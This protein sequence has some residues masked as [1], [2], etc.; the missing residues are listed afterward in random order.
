MNIGFTI[1]GPLNARIS[2]VN[3]RVSIALKSVNLPGRK[4][5]SEATQAATA[6]LWRQCGLQR[7]GWLVAAWP[8]ASLNLPGQYLPLDTGSLSR[9]AAAAGQQLPPSNLQTV[10]SKFNLN[11]LRKFKFKF[12][13]K[14][15]PIM[16]SF[17]V[18]IG[19]PKKL[20][21]QS[22]G[23]KFKTLPLH[24]HWQQPRGSTCQSYD[25]GL[26][27]SLSWSYRPGV[28]IFLAWAKN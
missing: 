13:G 16:S 19:I 10:Q 6:P 7:R 28:T 26:A 9:G 2:P 4:F 11:L 21:Q 25:L 17:S 20:S 24:V 8:F 27:A 23:F 1:T 12:T 14:L 22:R 15:I 3:V 18:M 5:K